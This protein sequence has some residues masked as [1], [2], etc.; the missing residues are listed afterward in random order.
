MEAP[1]LLERVLASGATSSEA[2]IITKADPPFVITHVNDTWVHLCG[3]SREEAVGQT[4][5]I[6]Q[7]PETA[8]DALM[9]L[10]LA[11]KARA[12]ISVCLLNYTKSGMPFFNQ[13]FVRPLRESEANADATHYLGTLRAFQLPTPSPQLRASSA[14]QAFQTPD[15][16]AKSNYVLSR[17]PSTLQDALGNADVPQIVTEAAPPFRIV[18]VNQ[19]WC[20]LCGYAAEEVIG[21]TCKILQGPGT[22]PDTLQALKAAALLQEPIGVRLVNYS[23]VR[24]GAAGDARTHAHTHTR[25]HAHTH[26]RASEHTHARTH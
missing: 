24:A 12:S 26:A 7:G 5:R 6:L 18:H 9:S 22:C 4:S 16:E 23:K 19:M 25:T 15:E 8:G 21:A 11:V 14:P 13:L 20:N 10:H 3:Y 2:Q 17:L 1:E